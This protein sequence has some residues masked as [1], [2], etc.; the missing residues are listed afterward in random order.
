[1]VFIPFAL[2]ALNKKINICRAQFVSMRLRV[3]E[4]AECDGWARTW[5]VNNFPLTELCWLNHASGR[6]TSVAANTRKKLYYVTLF[7]ILHK[8]IA[9]KCIGRTKHTWLMIG[10]F[11]SSRLIFLFLWLFTKCVLQQL[12]ATPPNMPASEFPIAMVTTS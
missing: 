7:I 5:V 9:S 11:T 12:S 2:I 1:M 4:S 3:L 6:S 10:W 8:G